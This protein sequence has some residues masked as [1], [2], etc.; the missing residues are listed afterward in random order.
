VDGKPMPILAKQSGVMQTLNYSKGGVIGNTR[1]R[2]A[3][4]GEE[5]SEG[6]ILI[7]PILIPNI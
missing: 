1:P 2:A 6:L 7:S 4:I 3:W 5:S